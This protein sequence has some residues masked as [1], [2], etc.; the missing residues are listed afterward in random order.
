MVF[1]LLETPVGRQF[2]IE[3]F[4]GVGRLIAEIQTSL[5]HW[6]SKETA[7]SLSKRQQRRRLGSLSTKGDCTQ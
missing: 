5:S 4:F 2:Q 1:L 3:N 6:A 7:L